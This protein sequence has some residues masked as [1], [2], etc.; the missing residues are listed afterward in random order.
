[1]GLMQKAIETYDNMARFV[2][3]E[4][5]NAEVLAPIGHIIARANIEITLNADG[6]F[7]QARPTNQKIPIPVT[8]E[9]AGRTSAP[10]AHALDEQLGYLLDVESDKTKLY[11]DGL[12]AWKDSEYTNKKLSAVYSYI[13]SGAISNDLN[14]AGLLKIDE[15][16][17]V[18]NEKELVCWIIIGL[19]EDSGPVWRDTNLLNAYSQYYIAKNA[20]TQ[21]E[22]CMLTGDYILPA[23][24]HL[25]GLVP[26]NGNAKLISSNDHSNFT[27]RGRFEEPE[28]ACSVGYVA[29]QKAHNALKWLIAN[30][31]VNEGGRTFLCWSPHGQAIPRATNA[32]IK[33]SEI[34]YEPSQYREQLRNVLQS[35]K[36][37]LPQGEEVVIAAFDAATTGRLAITYYNELQ[38]SDFLER[39]AYWDDTCCWYDNR[40]GTSSPSLY[41][42]IQYAFGIQRGEAGKV[43]IDEKIIPQHMQRLL[44]CRLEQ[45]SFPR[46]ILMAIVRKADNIQVLSNT[47]RS[48][49]LFTACAIV[50]KYR[51]DHLKEDIGMTLDPSRPD[52]SYQFGRLLAVMEKIEADTYDKAETRE[53]NAIRMQSVFVRRPGYATKIIMDQLKNGYYPR[54]KTG[55]RVFYDKLIGE[56]MEQISAF[57]AEEYNK[58]LTETYLP[59]YY[60]QKN[61]LYTKK[62]STESNN[63]EEEM[64]DE[65]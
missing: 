35:Y 55:Q 56:I 11:L 22:L 45:S 36:A 29:S 12:R 33:K 24:Q 3:V 64:N 1:M 23:H 18:K 26:I 17:T 61:A 53:T 58:S 49:L 9:S 10:A 40:W 4:R 27:Y 62:E 15:K 19:G 28:E 20:D 16:G 21:K 59:G 25:K 13:E 6:H 60:L 31:G 65:I 48:Q 54:L 52:R 43:E 37:Q 46:D 51:I 34:K 5:E 2:G 7:I 57:P 44:A 38:A 41:S 8:E 39:L 30:D 42:I 32:L 47:N 50:R 14:N 63:A